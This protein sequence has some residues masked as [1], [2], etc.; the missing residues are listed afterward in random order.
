MIESSFAISCDKD[1]TFDGQVIAAGSEQFGTLDGLTKNISQTS[2]W[3]NLDQDFVDK[4]EFSDGETTF[5]ITIETSDNILLESEGTVV[6][7][8]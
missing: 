6:M 1:F 3:V 8:F 4:A 7:D 2:L 5:T